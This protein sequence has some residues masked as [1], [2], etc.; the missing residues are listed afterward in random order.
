MPMSKDK[1]HPGMNVGDAQPNDDMSPRD[2]E[3]PEQPMAVPTA[4]ADAASA[5]AASADDKDESE[6]ALTLVMHESGEDGQPPMLP[7]LITDPNGNQQQAA[8]QQQPPPEQSQTGPPFEKRDAED[9][10][11]E[12]NRG[13]RGDEDSGRPP[14]RRE[15]ERADDDPER[16]REARAYKNP[17]E[18]RAE[19]RIR[20]QTSAE[21]ETQAQREAEAR[22]AAARTFGETNALRESNARRVLR[23][24]NESDL[25]TWYAQLEQRQEAATRLGALSLQGE[26]LTPEQLTAR[27]ERL[28]GQKVATATQQTVGAVP[29][30]DLS[31]LFTK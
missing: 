31:K 6:A 4:S 12:E 14:E 19:E 15:E 13:P 23:L 7:T 1:Q 22:E 16:R 11:G 29:E 2:T 8:P 10:V 30:I 5:D 20:D 21:D 27:A 17:E 18:H 24:D 3:K 28:R 9:P 25:A 26:S